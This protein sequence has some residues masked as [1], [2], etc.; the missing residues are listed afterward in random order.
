MGDLGDTSDWIVIFVESVGSF[1]E[2]GIFS[3]LQHAAAVTA[4]AVDRKHRYDASFLN[5]GP[6]N[7]VQKIGYP[8]SCAFYI[9][10]DNP[11]ADSEFA[12]FTS[13]LRENVRRGNNLA[14]TRDRKKIN[15][16]EAVIRVGS[17]AHELLDLLNPIGPMPHQDPF[18]LYCRIKG[19]KQAKIKVS[20]TILAED[21]KRPIDIEIDDVLDLLIAGSLVSVR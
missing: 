21:M 20:S 9:D 7:E 12:S 19:F 11:F 17:L 6:V 13:L 14:V 15:T 3:V 4:I 8:L 1:C 16:N 2:L 5:E 10:L 18:D